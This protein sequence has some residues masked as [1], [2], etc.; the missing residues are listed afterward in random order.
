[1]HTEVMG[2]VLVAAGVSD[3]LVAVFVVGPR[4]PEPR[5]GT[6]VAAVA[7]GGGLMVALGGCMLGGVL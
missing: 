4:V 7:A 3:V 5:R 1:M 6:V 2:W